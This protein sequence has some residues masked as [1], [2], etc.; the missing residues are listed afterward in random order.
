MTGKRLRASLIALLLAAAA[1]SAA[2]PLDGAIAAYERGDYQAAFPPL[3]ALAQRG[4]PTAQVYVGLMYYNG[5]GVGEDDASSFDWFRRA[6]EQGDAEGQF[7]LGFMYLYGFGVPAEI[8]HPEQEAARLFLQAAEQGHA[9]AQFNLGLM[10][11]AGSGVVRDETAGMHW[12][13]QA[14]ANGDPGARRFTG[15]LD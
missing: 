13:E 10:L 9:E 6:A 1:A 4:E 14:A 8:P 15:A 3:L 2:A 12:I 7:Q 11:L 5:Q